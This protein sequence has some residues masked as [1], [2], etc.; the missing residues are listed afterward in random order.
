MMERGEVLKP[1]LRRATDE[2]MVLRRDSRHVTA[3]GL[4][5]AADRM[6]AEGPKLVLRPGMKRAAVRKP[7]VVG[8]MDEVLRRDSLLVREKTVSLKL[9]SE[10]GDSCFLRKN[11]FVTGNGRKYKLSF[12]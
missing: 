7:A 3:G 9:V 1:D 6:T 11:P 4:S 12:S 10:A 5:S 2:D 8:M